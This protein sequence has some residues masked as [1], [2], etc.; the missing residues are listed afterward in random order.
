M[1]EAKGGQSEGKC[2]EGSGNP[3]VWLM[4]GEGGGCSSP[5]SRGA[6]RRGAALPDT[7]LEGRAV[8]VRR[9]GRTKADQGRPEVFRPNHG[10]NGI[11]FSMTGRMEKER[12]GGWTSDSHAEMCQWQ[13]DV[14][15]RGWEQRCKADGLVARRD[16]EAGGNG[17][18]RGEGYKACAP[19][20]P[21]LLRQ[22]S[23]R[24]SR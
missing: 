17:C 20:H 12:A 16:S 13:V 10:V 2:L 18:R 24:H 3:G 23:S 15:R 1:R 22:A 4:W 11:P 6:A 21:D 9:C 19:Q 7:P 5:G 14:R 8:G